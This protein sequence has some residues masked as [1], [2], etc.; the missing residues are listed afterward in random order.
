MAD[1][2]NSS[3][4]ASRLGGLLS[5]VVGLGCQRA[6][7]PAPAPPA[8]VF[9]PLAYDAPSAP[10][11]A[12]GVSEGPQRDYFYREGPSAV[13]LSLRSGA[14]PRLLA[15]FPAND[16]GIGV[17]FSSPSGT[18][19]LFAGKTPDA[20]PSGGGLTALTRDGG[21]HALHG[22]RAILKSSATRLST[23]LVLLGSVRTLRDYGEGLCLEDATKFPELRNEKVELDEA[24]GVLRIRR[25]Q[26]GGGHSMELLLAG[27]SGTSIKLRSREVAA[28]SKCP[29]APG[30]GQ[31]VVD[32]SNDAGIELQ[33][34]AL[35]DEEP[36]TPIE[37]E[38]VLIDPGGAAESPELRALAFLSYE[39]KLLAGS[40]RFLSYFGRD[41]L[42]S[43][44]LLLPKLESRVAVAAL[45]AVL[46]RVQ[47]ADGV[48]APEG[49]VI[50]PGDVAHEEE[51]G[52]YAAWKNSRAEPRPSD[53]RQPRYDYKMVD[54]DFLLAP[55]VVSLAKK[56]EA[57]PLDGS[58][59]SAPAR[60]MASFLQ[61]KRRD[62]RAYEEALLANLALVLTRARPFAEDPRPAAEKKQT[63]V[64]LHGG[65][66]VGQWRDSEEGLAFGRYPFD[67][68]AALVPAALEA[69][70]I[71]Y[72]RLGRATEAADAKRLAAAWRN[73]EDLFRLELPLE[74]AR[75]NVAT[76][77][78]SIGLT[79][80]SASIEPDTKDSVVEYG[81]ALDAELR[82]LP[83]QHSDHGFVLE[84][85]RPSDAYLRHVASRITRPFPAGLMSPAG[86]MVANPAF[87]A[88]DLLVT[89][90]KRTEDP[91]DDAST[92]LRELF[93]SSRYHG[94]VV[95]SWQ[96]ALLASGVRRQ[97]L[98]KDLS[99]AARTALQK[100]ECELWQVIDATRKSSTRELWSWAPGSDGRPEL[101]PF[102]AAPGDVDEA[103]AI[104][105][106]STVYLAVEKPTARQ[107]PRCKAESP[108]P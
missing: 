61:R 9:D 78:A 5:L 69:A 7:S 52:D 79:D 80:P 19:E 4:S 106:W 2:M 101:R 13:H 40:W 64:A 95:W 89:D 55:L 81:I 17:W 14:S 74:Q 59:E 54:D 62:G 73:I 51:V 6:A 43:L 31:Q 18:A 16:Q 28:R 24:N 30:G 105:L 87:A 48:A 41:T 20:L 8:S 66:Q 102:G 90:R 44:R 12:F 104:Q 23:D 83:V 88:P 22:V 72:E 99:G 77:A 56:L 11:L 85:A 50:S 75:G 97:L 37:A 10:R 98:R 76:Y 96:Q 3:M 70:R 86:I 32:M 49:G 107:N 35:S 47:L 57:H 60:A 38:D 53:L 58:P 42:M 100:A 94:T 82:P 65:L 91:G 36:L 63:L 39:E 27:L 33:L 29:L 25:E 103:N 92:P 68:N 34:I 93:T 67:V 26:I 46:E 15:A 45:G 1:L 108:R 21:Q 84:L 71:I